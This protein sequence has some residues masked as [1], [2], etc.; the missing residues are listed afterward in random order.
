MRGLRTNRRLLLLRHGKAESPLGL[1]DA[2]RPLADRGRAQAG[3]AGRQARERGIVP[4]LAIVSPA[5]RTRQTW[6]E[7]AD[8]MGA[9][10]K[11]QPE[12]EVDMAGPEVEVEVDVDRR[13]YDNTVDDLLDVLTEAP[14]EVR[15][16]LVVGHNPSIASLAAVL[17][18]GSPGADRHGLA[19]GYPTGTLTVFDVAGS[20][21]AVGPGS[22]R[23]RAVIRRPS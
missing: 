19:D 1:A 23:L 5:L 22:G 12:V 16:L 20:W 7:F 21:K 3:Y 18:D 10:A 13:V 9:S 2:D 17:D 6:S 11:P 8:A 4:D 15:T 14:D